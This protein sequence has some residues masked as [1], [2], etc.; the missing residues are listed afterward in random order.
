MRVLR[1]RPLGWAQPAQ[2]YAIYASGKCKIDAQVVQPGIRLENFNKKIR[3]IS[4]TKALEGM[5]IA[6]SG[7]IV[8]WNSVDRQRGA[9]TLWTGKE[10]A[11]M[12]EYLP[13]ID[14]SHV[15]TAIRAQLERLEIRRDDLERCGVGIAD[16]E[17]EVIRRID[18]RGWGRIA[19]VMEEISASL[20]LAE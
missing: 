3:K 2:G 6:S 17:L 11:K 7:G 18:G 1:P 16:L 5:K 15:R 20:G 13:G 19:E 4:L 14:A 9:G 10:E 8:R 12:D